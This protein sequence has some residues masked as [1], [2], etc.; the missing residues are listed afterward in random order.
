MKGL[1][2]DEPWIGMILRGEKTWE[3]RSRHTHLRGAVALIRKG[4]G[5]VVG[6]T[7]VVG[8]QG[9]L[10]VQELEASGVRHRVPMA[11]F[12]SGRASA[13][14]IAWVLADTVAIEAPVPYRHPHGAVVWVDLDEATSSRIRMQTGDSVRSAPIPVVTPS[15]PSDGSTQPTKAPPETDRAGE[16]L[17]PVSKDGAWFGPH[18]LRA[19]EFTI[20]AKG[21]EVRTDDFH[22]ALNAL[23]RMKVPRW[24]RP[25]AKGN[26]GIVSGVRWQ[27]LS[28][29]D[30]TAIG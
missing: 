23:R 16:P 27:R 9:P 25:N 5:A 2:V 28:E 21:E 30:P 10:S 22:Q 18:L 14:N 7:H 13:W 24:R 26:W 12:L 19:G 20:G 8:C 17:V 3:M 29:C 11:E 4:S 15:L 6:V 1:I